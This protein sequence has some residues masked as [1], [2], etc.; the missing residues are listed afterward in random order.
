MTRTGRGAPARA[1]LAL[2]AGAVMMAVAACGSEAALEPTGPSI[3]GA[4]T[5]RIPVGSPADSLLLVLDDSGTVVTGVGYLSPMRPAVLGGVGT[6]VEDHLM[7]SLTSASPSGGQATVD[8]S[9]Q[10]AEDANRFDGTA[11]VLGTTY[12]VQLRRAALG[13]G[14]AAGNWVL[15]TVREPS[16]AATIPFD[17]LRLDPLGSA[18]RGFANASCGYSVPG[19]V[20]ESG[21]WV[22]VE[23]FSAS[24]YGP[25]CNPPMRDSLQLVG[26]TLVRR[27]ALVGGATRE[28]LYRRR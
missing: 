3:E 23:Y 24:G 20:G 11:T 4:W 9:L 5:A 10:R 19:A 15:T 13:S 8:L 25:P 18:H 2:Y 6:L 14:P 28:E 7:L 27:T 1:V 17:T 26:D 22:R 16:P 12:P 21:G